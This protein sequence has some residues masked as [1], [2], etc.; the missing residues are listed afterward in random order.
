MIVSKGPSFFIAVFDGRWG[1]TRIQRDGVVEEIVAVVLDRI[2]R[3]VGPGPVLLRRVPLSRSEFALVMW[4]LGRKEPRR[5]TR[6]LAKAFTKA[7]NRAAEQRV[8]LSEAIIKAR[9]YIN[10]VLDKLP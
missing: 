2:A 9:E 7:M 5:L 6:R 10:A 1:T 3:R 4:L 8:E